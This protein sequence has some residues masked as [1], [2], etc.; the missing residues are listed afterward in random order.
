MSGALPESWIEIQLEDI[1]QSMESGGRPKGG[2]KGIIEGIPS[3]GGE[4]LNNA[5]GFNFSNMRYVP[6]QFYK[7]MLKGHIAENDVLIVKDGATTGKASFVCCDFPFDK[8]VVNEH[9]FVVRIAPPLNKKFVFYFLWSHEGNRRI[10]E[11]FQGSAQGGIN[12]QFASRTLIPMP[13]LNEQKRIVAKLDAIMPRIDSVKERL[14]KIPA[15]LKRFR[16]SVL[17]AA[18]TG[19]LTEKW[20]EEHPEVEAIF[21]ELSNETS[22]LPENWCVV[23][24]ERLVKSIRTDLRTGPFGTTLKKEEHQKCGVPVWGIESIG[25]SGEFTG[26]N[27]I[28]VSIEKAKELKSFQVNGGDI[29]ISRSGTV[30][31]LC[32]L[33]ENIEYG[34]LSTNL[35]KISL[36]RS[37]IDSRVFCFL[38]KGSSIVLDRIRELCSGSTRLFLTQAILKS[39]TYPLPPLDEQKEI[40]R[41]VDKLFAL[42]DKVEEHYQKARARVDALA[43]SV[44]AK[45]F[46]GELVPQ[47]PDDEPAEKLLQR[48]QEEKT[49]LEAELKTASRSVRETRKNGAKTQRA[50]SEEKQASEP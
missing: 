7:G 45:A 40:V 39:I 35:L 15:I 49:K 28:Y 6:E 19:E 33:P 13:P 42:A 27:K 24:F 32:I 17:T 12:R 3:I 44:L 47:N 22:Y 30:G 38:F 11:N 46:R 23:P 14:E 31:E 48:I 43:Q 1:I 50:R 26:I 2:V 9:V 29:I 34:L 21:P 5:G 37:V 36:N 10:L 25:R 8:A 20:R 41:Q 4:H 18:V 16:Q